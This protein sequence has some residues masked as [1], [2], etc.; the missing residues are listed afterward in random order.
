[1]SE[2]KIPTRSIAE[3]IEVLGEQIQIYWKEQWMEMVENQRNCG[4]FKE[5]DGE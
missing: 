4:E 5:R 2:I 1:M 3:W